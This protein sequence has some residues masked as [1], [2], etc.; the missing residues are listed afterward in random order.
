[1]VRTISAASQ[2]KLDQDLGTEPAII[3]E[4]QWVDGGSIYTYSDKNITSNEGKILEIS[5]LD[6]TVVVQGSQ[7]GTSGDSQQIS[8]T[9]DDADGT[10]KA[11]MD[12]HD[13]HKEI[14]W[15]YQWFQ[16]L[17]ISEKFLVFKGQVSSPIQWNEGDRTISFDIITRIEDAEVGFSMEEGIFDFVP[18]NLIGQPWP[19]VFGTVKTCPTLKTVSPRTGILKTGFGIRDFMLAPKKEQA[20]Q[21]CCGGTIVGWYRHCI[22]SDGW[23]DVRCQNLPRITW[24]EACKCKRRTTI[25]D[26]ELNI[27]A[28][29]QHESAQ[30]EILGGEFFP[31]GVFVTLNIQGSKISGKFQGTV[32]SPSTIFNIEKRVHP[33]QVTGEIT[34]PPIKLFSGLG[35]GIDFG[36]SSD[37]AR[38]AFLTAFLQGDDVG[39]SYGGQTCVV[40]SNCDGYSPIDTQRLVY[41]QNKNRASESW[42]YLSTF[43]KAGFFWADP[44]AEV[45]LDFEDQTIYI[46]NILPSTV[47]QVKAWRIFNDSNARLL[48]TVPNTLYTVR[49]SDF[50]PYTVTEIVFEKP[51]SSLGEGWED[52]IFVTHTSS[53]GPNTVDIMEWLITMYTNFTWD[54]SFADVKTKIDNYPMNF[55]VPGKPNILQLLQEMAFQARCALTL[56][57]DEF[58]LTY[59][60]EEPEQDGSVNE[61]DVLF[62]SLVL[63]H[64]NTEELVTKFIAEW[65]PEGHLEDPYSII[66]RYNVSRYGVQEETFDFYTYNIREL[67]VKS[68]TFWLIRMANTWRKIICKTPINKLALE[69][70]DG[71]FVTLNDIA[72]GEI[73]CRIETATYNSDDHTIDFVIQTPV[74]SG[75]RTPYLFHYP[76]DV[77]I[78]DFFPQ[79]DAIDDGTAGGSGPN[80]DVEAPEGHLLGTPLTYIDVS[81]SHEPECIKTASR[82]ANFGPNCGKKADYGDDQPSDIDDIKPTVPLQNDNSIIPPTQ[83]PYVTINPFVQTLDASTLEQEA[84]NSGIQQ[85]ITD[86]V[87]MGTGGVAGLADNGGAGAGGEDGTADSLRQ[88]F[89][90]MPS[91]EEL[92]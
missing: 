74:R 30:V 29:A 64:T 8:V 21:L 26:L 28:Q 46:V 52:D 15:V 68:S 58:H 65:K 16:G 63:D 4:I 92:E 47:H 43:K 11:I 89:E 50:S 6:N 54:S 44:G 33:K 9:L 22:G 53:I 87:Y 12:S 7:S 51:L 39:N 60:S 3:V 73:K 81:V 90:D 5:G 72:D 66:L 88:T 42:D 14:A 41:N 75:E 82:S 91:G 17:D 19:L 20:G 76:S 56:R 24:D 38:N 23:R 45:R 86:S 80:V 25:C 1:M 55:K 49:Q 69:S 79:K 32:E 61:D 40:P 71:C 83:D 77:D 70:I 34:I 57:D 2:A 35:C 62:N 10:I 18:E 27:A 36:G 31:Q 37:A 48:T 78:E 67:V 13:I 85:Q 84:L 59:L